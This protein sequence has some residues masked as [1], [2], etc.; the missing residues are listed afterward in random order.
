MALIFTTS[1][2]GEGQFLETNYAA[3]L[4]WRNDPGLQQQ[5]EGQDL[6]AVVGSYR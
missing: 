3:P 4:L 5:L 6:M 1:Q 2:C